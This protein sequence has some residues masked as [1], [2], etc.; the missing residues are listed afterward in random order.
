MKV[1]IYCRVSTDEQNV[2]SQEAHC[3]EYCQRMGY[4]VFKVYKD[5]YTGTSDNRPMF[6]ELLHDM[7]LYRFNA[8]MVT[9][10]DRLTRSLQHLL[11]L[12]DE[13]KLKGV[14]LICSTQEINTTTP[15][16]IFQMHVFG[17][18]SEFERNL[19]SART[20]E[21]FYRDSEGKLRSRKSHKLVGVRG[22]DKHPRL[23]R[24]VLRKAQQ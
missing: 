18:V 6:N 16:G 24:G 15:A 11:G 3:L 8:I 10:L 12:I 4:E 13:F 5:V 19:I 23:K 21:S 20:K 17:A 7:R 1:A 14:G 2:D 9:R 22:K